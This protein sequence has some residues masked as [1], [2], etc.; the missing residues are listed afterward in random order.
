M[1]KLP[2][3]ISTL[4]LA[5]MPE[6][7]VSGVRL[8]WAMLLGNGRTGSR[9]SQP[10]IAHRPARAA[11]ITSAPTALLLFMPSRPSPFST[12]STKAI[13]GQPSDGF[14]S[15]ARA[16]EMIFGYGAATPAQAQLT[17]LITSVFMLGLVPFTLFYVLFR[18]FYAVEDTRT[19][20][21]ASVVM[22]VVALG[23]A[24]PLFYAV[25]GGL[26]VASLAF[27]YV[28][29]FWATFIVAWIMLARR[30]GGLDSWTTV[31]SLLRMLIAGF[32]AFCV[33]FGTEAALT[34][35]VTGDDPANTLGVLIDVV[36][37][38]AVGLGVYL[39]AAWA[40]RIHEVGDVVQLVQRKVLRRRGRSSGEDAADARTL[41][42]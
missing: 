31:R 13:V 22:N 1:T 20:F 17:G 41:E 33:M 30:L 3:I 29:G 27:G 6:V 38:S 40:M 19:P 7:A 32:I 2:M 14:V 8:I 24:I 15:V 21:I 18:G 9:P 25:S 37:L 28:C 26:Q 39:A 4:P 23:V 11:C 10:S 16:D 36:V 34:A 42:G 35:Y 12:A 5:T